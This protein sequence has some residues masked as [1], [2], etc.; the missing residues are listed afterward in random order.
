M[1]A[2]DKPMSKTT[3]SAASSMRV[4]LELLGG[5]SVSMPC[6][7]IGIQQ[8]QVHLTT[9]KRVAPGARIALRINQLTV[10]GEVDY[11]KEKKGEYLTCII[12]ESRRGSPR[13]LIDEPGWL[14]T[15]T[16]EATSTRCKCSLTDLSQS[17]LGLNS[18]VEIKVGCMIC[19]QTDSML[20][21]GEVRY[22]RQNNAGSF[23]LGV[24]VTD[25]LSGE[26]TNQRRKG[27]RHRIAE[28]ILGRRIGPA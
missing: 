8:G 21:V 5:S 9:K 12:V 24:A 22:Q 18:P 20:A 28:A 25:V 3:V 11:C 14:I 7:L 23:H 1:I 19:I 15:L 26:T 10:A 16:G 17:G 6:D 4:V 13:F 27:L 2:A